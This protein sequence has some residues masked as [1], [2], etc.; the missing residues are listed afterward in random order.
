MR[1]FLAVVCLLAFGASARAQSKEADRLNNAA[2]VIE[3][4][5]G[6]PE[7]AVPLDLLKRAVC[8]GVIP[9]MK[10][11]A[12]G[13]GGSFGRGA[14]VCRNG[15]TGG[16]GAP[17][18]ITLRGGSFGLQL[19]GLATD[20]LL[21]VGNP[22]GAE[23]L[24]RSKGELGADVSVAAGPKGRTAAA[25]TDPFM[26][27]EILTYSRSKG[28]F[29]GISLKGSALTADHD[30]NQRLYGRRLEP[31]DILIRGGVGVP[32]AARTFVSAL[33]KYAPTG[34]K[35]FKQAKGS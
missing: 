30:A 21:F 28:L 11:A 15:G 35:P 16:W 17:S 6:T 23:K 13:F 34:G 1:P 10:K 27:A 7:K 29:A 2:A 33:N 22:K 32:G 5:M 4:V 24:L 31:H 20:V 3:E 19:G 26:S 25:A 8:I 9:S 18:M 12:L 14:L